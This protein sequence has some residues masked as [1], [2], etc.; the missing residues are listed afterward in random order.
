MWLHWNTL[1]LVVQ[2]RGIEKTCQARAKYSYILQPTD[3]SYPQDQF[4]VFCKS[5]TKKN[6]K[7]EK[8][9]KIKKQ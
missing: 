6:R 8:N 3:L 4:D 2:T 9:K 7:Q 5:E 1:K